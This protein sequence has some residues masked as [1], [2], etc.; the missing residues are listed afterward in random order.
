MK[1]FII[2]RILLGIFII[3]FGAMIIYT[4]I[5]LLPT[6]YV[7]QIARQRASNPLSTKSYQE[8]LDQLNEVYRLNVGIIPGYFGWLGN[9]IR[10][11]F[12]ESWHY[13]I[14][15]TQKFSEVVW[16]SFIINIITFLVELLISIPLGILAARK[17]YSRTDYAITVFALAGISLP[18]FS[19]R[20]Y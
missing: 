5:R 11:D 7:E 8:W 18:S 20:P 19:W 17:Q 1:N 12:G 9:A 13:G 2:R 15:V 6:S 10:G 16:Y 14:P 4:V 3:F